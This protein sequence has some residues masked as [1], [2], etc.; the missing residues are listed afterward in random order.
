MLRAA[1]GIERTRVS[2]GHARLS[3]SEIYADRDMSAAAD[4]ARRVG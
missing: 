2:M 1:F 4:V 3:T